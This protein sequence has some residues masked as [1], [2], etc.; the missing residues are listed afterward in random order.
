MKVIK[1]DKYNQFETTVDFFDTNLNKMDLREGHYKNS[2]CKFPNVKTI[3]RLIELSEF[4]AL[5]FNFIRIDFYTDDKIIKVGEI[6]N[7]DNAGLNVY[8]P[9]DGDVIISN[10]LFADFSH[11]SQPLT[12]KNLYLRE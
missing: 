10:V 11:D 1:F 4:L 5:P 3:E 7:C 12:S 8:S 9:S 2:K 6:T